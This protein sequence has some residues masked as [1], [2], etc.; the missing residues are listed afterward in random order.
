MGFR[1][2]GPG[3]MKS[4]NTYAVICFSA[5]VLWLLSTVMDG[6]LV[7]AV[8]IPNA[9]SF[10]LPVHIICLATV[11][12]FCSQSLFNRLVPLNCAMT[13]LLTML[14]PLA[15]PSA[16]RYLLA[17]LGASGAFVAI[18]ACITLRQSAAPL[19]S[20]A[21]GLVAANL[22]FVPV[23]VWAGGNFIQFAAVG[24]PLL[25]IPVLARR[26]PEPVLKVETVSRWHY[27]PFIVIIHIISGLMYAFILPAYYRFDLLPGIEL[28]FYILAVFAAFWMVAKNPDL[29]LVLGVLSGM[30]AFTLLHDGQSAL[31]INMGMFAMQSGAGFIDLVIIAILLAFPDPLRAFGIG[32]AA[33]CTGIIAGKGIGYYFVDFA[34][35]IV[36]IGHLVLNLS[37]LTL[38]FLGR[39]H[40]IAQN[41]AA[42]LLSAKSAHLSAPEGPIAPVAL[43]DHARPP[44]KD[45]TTIVDLPEHLRLLL[46]E[47]EY[48]VLKRAL[49]GRTYRE[50]AR[51]L[52]ISESTVKTYM[53]RIY[54]KMGV[55]GKRKLFEKLTQK[56]R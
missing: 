41:R 5:F 50:T 54:E 36:M 34:T 55:K 29:V 24:I 32:Q 31:R 26:M 22:L 15:D 21:L 25:A 28:L 39:Y 45:D 52:E 7:S 27:L 56:N 12:F 13:A 10:F 18:S 23:R 42:E 35:D 14:L 1:K 47:R 48:L 19:V 20:A 9:A 17:A 8:G 4:S 16:G 37:I 46:S 6:P 33:L 43:L 51:E 11:G 44:A 2:N 38:Y 49:A 40:F 53:T 30:A 3:S